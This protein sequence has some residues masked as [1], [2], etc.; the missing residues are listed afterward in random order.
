MPSVTKPCP[1]VRQLNSWPPEE[2]DLPNEEVRG[3]EEFLEGLK[4]DP[5]DMA[6]SGTGGSGE[7][8]RKAFPPLD[9]E[10][11][12]RIADFLASRP[13]IHSITDLLDQFPEQIGAE[14]RTQRQAASARQHSARL[15]G[16]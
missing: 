11:Y 13:D 9:M 4:A 10:A 6:R 7:T 15:G 16:A 12:Q 14:V 3:P 8:P 1:A 5:C 2:K